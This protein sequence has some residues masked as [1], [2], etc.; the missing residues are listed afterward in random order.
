MYRTN[1]DENELLTQVKAKTPMGEFLRRYWWPVGFSEHLKDKPTFIKILGEELV[2]FRDGKGKAGVIGA[3]CPHRRANMCLGNVEPLGLRCRYHGRLLDTDGNVLEI[4]GEP[5]DSKLKEEIDH[6]AYPTEELGGF[7]FTYLGPQPAPLLPRYDFLAGDG[8]IYIT[9]QGFQN[10]NWLQ[11][12][13]NGLDPVHVSFTHGGAWPDL[14]STEPNLGFEE[15]ELGLVYK[16]LR[17]PKNTDKLNYR[18]HHLL[19]PGISCGGSGG[20]YLSGRQSGT[21][22]SAARWSVPI[23]ETHT[24]LMRSRFKP[25]DNPARFEGD[26]FTER[27]KPSTPVFEPFKEYK[28]SEEPVLGYNIPPLHMIEDGMVIDSIGPVSDR[29]NENL[30]SVIDEGIIMLRQMYLREIEKVAAGKD[31]KGI[32]RDTQ[33]ND[34][35]TITAYEKWISEEEQNAPLEGANTL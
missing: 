15:T 34:V 18:E 23:D 19:M 2:L 24:L 21:A 8:E 27:W 30:S 12:V 1:K 33:K 10:C 35:I 29:E 31:P 11:C 22:L 7:V 32:I 20:R 26:P 25:A 17:R 5:E 3:L 14:R 6:L 9:I 4:P 13:E 28:T 16:A